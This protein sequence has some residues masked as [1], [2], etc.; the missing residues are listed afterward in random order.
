MSNVVI[1]K[2]DSKSISLSKVKKIN[3]ILS[4]DKQLSTRDQKQILEAFKSDSFEM[5]SSFVWLKAINSLKDLLAKLGNNIIAEILDR[6]DIKEDTDLRQVLTEFETINLSEELGVISKTSA[7]R[8]RQAYST[9]SYFTQNDL[10]EDDENEMSREEAVTVLKSCISG[11]L[12]IQNLNAAIDFQNFRN[13]LVNTVLTEDNEHVAKLLNSP[14]FYYRTVIRILLS[15]VKNNE[16]AQLSNS[17]ANANLIIPLIWSKLNDPEK[18]HIGKTYAEIFIDGK[19]TAARGFKKVLLKVNGFDFV[20]EDLRSNTYLEAANNVIQVHESGFNFYYEP[21]AIMKLANLGS[22][23]P[24]S[25]FPK[26]MSAVLSIKL[27]NFYNISWDAQKYADEILRGLTPER[28]HYF[29]NECISFDERILFKLTQR[30]PRN[31][32]YKLIAELNTNHPKVLVKDNL[33]GKYLK[34]LVQASLSK[35]DTSLR[36][37]VQKIAEKLGKKII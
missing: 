10:E 24:I 2:N 27:G 17:L 21:A 8:L 26:C 3:E 32:W 6:N 19:T 1:W 20:P 23:I 34:Q 28:W 11:I 36:E 14:Y 12:G 16:G 4:F 9:V 30:S 7:F 37:A 13:M 5:L 35:S 25:A 31:Y 18:R 15:M 22:N 29:F 33:K